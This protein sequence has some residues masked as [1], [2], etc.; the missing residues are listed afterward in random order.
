MTSFASDAVLHCGVEYDQGS[1][2]W[3]R[4]NFDQSANHRS[5]AISTSN[6]WVNH[7]YTRSGEYNITVTASNRVSNVT[8][9]RL[10]TV[11][12]PIDIVMVRTSSPTSVGNETFIAAAVN[13]GSHP[14]FSFNFGDG[15]QFYD[16]EMVGETFIL[17]YVFAAHGRHNVTVFAEN[18]VSM[19]TH[20]VEVIVEPLVND[21]KIEMINPAF[22]D[23]PAVFIVKTEGKEF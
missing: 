21:V 1:D 18:A 20:T 10:I 14:E 15:K 17:T 5:S 22:T 9:F 16:G 11:Q 13:Q 23:A 3:Y 6:E 8:Q 7:T 12:D 19:V 4:W 2:L